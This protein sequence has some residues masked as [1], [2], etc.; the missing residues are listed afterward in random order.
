MPG[1][2]AGE[3]SLETMDVEL[4]E[5]VLSGSYAGMRIAAR[6][7]RGGLS[8]TRSVLSPQVRLDHGRAALAFDITA[9][10]PLGVLA[11]VCQRGGQA[12]Y[13]SDGSE[14]RYGPGDVYLTLQPD[15]HYTATLDHADTEVAV[16]D[17]ALLSQVAG[18]APGRA[19]QPVR[20]T[21]YEPVSGRAAQTWK[22]ASAYV[23]GTV[24]ASPEMAAQPLVA[25]GATRLLAAV[26]LAA[27]PSNALAGPTAEDRHDA[28][29][30]ALR[31]ATA[32]IDEHA[33]ED[34]TAAGIAAAA[35]V[36]V[37]AVQLAFRRHLDTTPMAYLRRARLD[38][39][40]RDLLAADPARTTVTTIAHRWGF[41]SA[42]R[43]AASYHH[44]FGVTPSHTLRQD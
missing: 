25:A 31:R 39:A 3:Q 21:G 30:D 20:F 33:H 22:T 12:A 10:S 38:A 43:F 7:Q 36:S 5:Q 15:H 35:Y 8:M 9:G 17:S 42:S 23:R 44:A 24:L 16:L 40:H 32:F 41:A 26:A 34:I 28:H 37:R 11:I 29:P 18:T 19:R 6:G 4:I 27:F 13:R 1:D 2:R 14:R